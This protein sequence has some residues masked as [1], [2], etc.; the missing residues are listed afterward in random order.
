MKAI[1][2]SALFVI[3]AMTYATVITVDNNGNAPAGVE[4]SIATAIGNATAGDTLLIIPSSSTYGNVNVTK[5]LTIIGVGFNPD[6]EIP[7][8]SQVSNLTIYTAA[9]GSKIIGLEITGYL[10]LGNT[11][12]ALSDLVI[13]NN[14]INYISNSGANSLTNVLIRQNVIQPT[15]TF[16]FS[17]NLT[18]TNQS[19]IRVSN[20][21]FANTGTTNQ[22]RGAYVTTGGVTFD[23]NTFLGTASQSAFYQLINCLVTNNIFV[24]I[25]PGFQAGGSANVLYKNNLSN[26][27]T[28]GSITG[29]N[30]RFDSNIDTTDPTFVNLPLTTFS[31]DYSLDPTLDAGSAGE[32]AATDGTNLGVDGGTSPFKL[33]GSV[34]PV[35]R[36]FD[37]PSNITEGTDADATIEVTGN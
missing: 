17:I 3:S 27:Y 8:T 24:T 9:S 26:D 36:R 37:L 15:P 23:H 34:L 21:V 28:F 11:S 33:S 4:T 18:T 20:N 7:F 19:N 10:Y 13:E 30:I 1:I 22:Y 6:M 35:V 31:Y 2:F 25:Y 14:R 12:G 29:T 32:N 5:P 16:T